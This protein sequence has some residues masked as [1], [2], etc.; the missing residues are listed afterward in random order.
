MSDASGQTAW[1]FDTIGRIV[2]EERTIAGV[3]KTMSYGNNLDGSVASITYPSGRTVSYSYSNAARQVSAVDSASMIN[4]AT[5]ATYAPQGALSSV[6]NG[7]ASGFNGITTSY[8]Y[9]RGLFPTA[10]SAT[11]PNGTALSLS[12]SYYANGNVDAETNGRDSGRSVTYGYDA[13]NRVLGAA[14]QATSGSDCWEQNFGYDQY[15]NLYS[16][17][18]SRCSSPTL[19]LSVN[20]KNQIT[21]SGFSYD[22]DGNLTADGLYIYSWNAENH[23]TSGNGVAY[24][25]D[26][27]LQRVK[28]S[29][30]TLYWYCA[31]CGKL[32][33]TTDSSGNIISEWTYFD[34]QRIARR[35]VSTGNVY[36]IFSDR[37]GSYRTL[38]N[39]TGTVEGESDYYPFGGERVISSTV[40]DSLRFAGMEWDS[41]D[42][43]NHTLYRQFT[44]AQGRWETPDPKRGCVDFPQGQNLYGYVRDNPTNFTDPS[45]EQRFPTPPPPGEGGPSIACQLC[46]LRCATAYATMVAGCVAFGFF[47]PTNAIACQVAAHEW[48]ISCMMQCEYGP[49][50]IQQAP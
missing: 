31:P 2:A 27:G 18:T 48:Y 36:Y 43:L 1:S 13:L 5:S 23:L 10:I 40:T 29:S 17:T 4:Y 25:Y 21:N 28:K 12:Y 39:S 50:E 22:A 37:L 30:G 47:A 34:N 33:A 9:N 11:S 38:T 44:P 14:S 6:L 45:G 42:G 19:N 35:D 15:A 20:S 26:G 24:T 16:I 7:P 8:S 46:E 41:E 49:C 32:L 3:T